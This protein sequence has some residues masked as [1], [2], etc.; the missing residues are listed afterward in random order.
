M[1][2]EID[3]DAQVLPMITPMREQAETALSSLRSSGHDL[4]LKGKFVKCR[5]CRRRSSHANLQKWVSN[6]C[7]GF[8]PTVA[9]GNIGQS[10]CQGGEST[11]VVQHQEVAQ[12]NTPKV[13]V[14]RARAKVIRRHRNKA[15]KAHRRQAKEVRRQAQVQAVHAACAEKLETLPSLQAD[16]LPFQVH[17]THGKIV[18]LGGYAGCLRCG[19]IA[20]VAYPSNRLSRECRNWC[21]KGT[22]GMTQR[23]LKGRHPLGSKGRS[24]PN[25]DS[26]PVPRRICPP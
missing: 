15:A 24:W 3:R 13:L 6:V 9:N 5:R 4:E 11:A 7:P 10:Q 1:L 12:T 16:Q 21:P 17:A 18:E 8:N 20:S 2:V 14:S 25:G 22:A 26:S 23:M 19:R